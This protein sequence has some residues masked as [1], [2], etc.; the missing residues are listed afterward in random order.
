MSSTE[1]KTYIFLIEGFVQGVGFRFYVSRKAILL[2]IQGYVKNLYDGKVEVVANCNELQY[3][4]LLNSLYIGSSRS[5]VK[6][7]EIDEIPLQEFNGIF[8]IK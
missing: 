6:S 7:I 2:D 1:F 8:Q 3:E 5:R 4:S